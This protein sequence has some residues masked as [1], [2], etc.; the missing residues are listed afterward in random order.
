MRNIIYVFF[1]ILV[2]GCK[3]NTK[4]T[5][6]KLRE[7]VEESIKPNLN[8]PK[9]YEFVS[10]EIDTTNRAVINTRIDDIKSLLNNYKKDEIKNKL[11]IEQLED[12]LHSTLEI[13]YPADEMEY[14]FKYRGKNA[15]N[16]TILKEE[17]VVTDLNGNFIEIHEKS[18]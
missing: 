3:E 15:F 12:Q 6:E 14:L 2:F 8:D 16:A 10:L 5:Q 1:F 4:S 9:S 7:D 11:M 18:R 13:Q 17:V